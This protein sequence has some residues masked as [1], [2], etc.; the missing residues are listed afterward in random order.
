VVGFFVALGW[1]LRSRSPGLDWI[2]AISFGFTATILVG[3][4][5]AAA[6][7]VGMLVLGEPQ[8]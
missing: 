8:R 6:Y 3:A 1:G 5:A 2:D 7:V 4:I